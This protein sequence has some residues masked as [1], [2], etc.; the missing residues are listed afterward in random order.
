MEKYI[1]RELLIFIKNKLLIIITVQLKYS[2]TKKFAFKYQY[3]LQLTFNFKKLLFFVIILNFT[4]SHM[5]LI[6]VSFMAKKTILSQKKYT[7]RYK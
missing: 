5:L 6:S 2:K 4:N 1:I 7:F 3:Y